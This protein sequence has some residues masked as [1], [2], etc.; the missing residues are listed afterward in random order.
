MSKM[1]QLQ[2]YVTGDIEALEPMEIDEIT[3]GHAELDADPEY[4]AW[5]DSYDNETLQ[6]ML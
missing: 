5:A 4:Q 3:E 2:P 1:G 6:V